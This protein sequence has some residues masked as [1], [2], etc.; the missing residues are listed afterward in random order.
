MQDDAGKIGKWMFIGAWVLIFGMLI[1]YFSGMLE[2]KY[3][4]NQTVVSAVSGG[5][6]EVQL[7]RNSMG[8]YVVNGT[9]NG[10]P[11]TFLLDTGATNVSIGA[12]LGESL[13]LRPGQRYQAQTANGVVSVASTTINELVIGDIVLNNV[14]ASLNPGMRDDKILLGMSALKHLDL[15]QSGEL[16][17]MKTR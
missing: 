14:D 4:P 10:K 13:G 17:T 8:H 5:I 3:N 1:A 15:L 6:A 12:H 9:I 2:R 7:L 11:V 16:L